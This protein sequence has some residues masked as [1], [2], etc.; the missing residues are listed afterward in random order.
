MDEDEVISKKLEENKKELKP[1]TK[2]GKIINKLGK[3]EEQ[4]SNQME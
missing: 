4:D 1:V 3:G 2:D